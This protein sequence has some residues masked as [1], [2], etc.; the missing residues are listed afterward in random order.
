M[1][2]VLKM[3]GILLGLR[4]LSKTEKVKN[5]QAVYKFQQDLSK[6]R[7]KHILRSTNSLIQLEYGKPARAVGIQCYTYLQDPIIWAKIITGAC[8][9]YQLDTEFCPILF[10]QS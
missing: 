7:E 9:C 10:S 6:Q 1:Y 2:R 8:N 4:I 5:C 3:S